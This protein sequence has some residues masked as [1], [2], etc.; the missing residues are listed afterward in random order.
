MSRIESSPIGHTVF[1]LDVDGVA[2]I[3]PATSSPHTPEWRDVAASIVRAKSGL[4]QPSGAP[5]LPPALAQILDD[6][7]ARPADHPDL[8]VATT[9]NA[10]LGKAQTTLSAALTQL[11]AHDAAALTE[12]IQVLEEERRLRALLALFRNAVLPG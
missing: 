12:A 6:A 9:F 3:H 5:A 10:L 2:S 7:L 8:L 11:N 1:D 4:S